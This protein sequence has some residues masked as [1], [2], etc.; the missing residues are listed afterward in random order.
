ML[1]H[2]QR[3]EVGIVGAK[4][5]YPNDTIQ[6]YGIMFSDYNFINCNFV[7]MNYKDFI[8]IKEDFPKKGI[9]FKDVT[10]L[11]ADKDAFK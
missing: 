2:C 11:I 5:L 9:S 8:A 4:L 3:D 10:P 1:S 6:H 7:N